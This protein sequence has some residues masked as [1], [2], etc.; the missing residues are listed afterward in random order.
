[1]RGSKAVQNKTALKATARAVLFW[2]TAC[3]RSPLPQIKNAVALYFCDGVGHFLFAEF[4]ERKTAT[5]CSWSRGRF[6]FLGIS[7][8]YNGDAISLPHSRGGE[9]GGASTPRPS[10]SVPTLEKLSSNFHKKFQNIFVRF[11]KIFLRPGHQLQKIRGL[12]TQHS[13]SFLSN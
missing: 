11:Q 12:K 5:R 2:I 1:M 3:F 9:P 7:E 8:A 13:P 6:F 4:R 10:N